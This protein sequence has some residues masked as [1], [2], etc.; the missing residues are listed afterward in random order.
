MLAAEAGADYVMFG[1]PDEDGRRP[2]FEPSSNASNGGRRCS[3]FPASGFAG[4]HRRDRA[5]GDRPAPTSSRSAHYLRRSARPALRAADAAP[6]S[7]CRR[8]SDDTR[9]A[10]PTPA[11][12]RTVRR[13]RCVHVRTRS[14]ATDPARDIPAFR[15]KRPPSAGDS[16]NVAG[17]PR[18][19][20]QG[21]AEAQGRGRSR[22]HDRS[23]P[24][25]HRR[26]QPASAAPSRSR[27]AAVAASADRTDCR[28]PSR[29][30]RAARVDRT[31]GSRLRRASSAAFY[32]TAFKLATGAS[33]STTTS[34]R[35]R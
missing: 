3:R 23:Q 15:R 18:E 27:V 14:G 22:L 28:P 2:S 17:A 16:R 24:P 34:R 33:S 19:T 21:G 26:Q 20:P 10:S 31:R 32:L 35:W 25:Q 12:G 9:S 5:A 13:A 29:P 4:I 6:S 1:E 11:G 8:P 30:G 7:R